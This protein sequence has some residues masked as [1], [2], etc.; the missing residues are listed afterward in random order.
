METQWCAGA[1]GTRRYRYEARLR[2]LRA[3]AGEFTTDRG[4]ACLHGAPGRLELAATATKPAY[5]GYARG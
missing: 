1:T 5:A 4:A 2:G 3:G